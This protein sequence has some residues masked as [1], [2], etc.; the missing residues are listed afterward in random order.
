MVYTS[1]NDFLKTYGIWFAVILCV[2]ILLVVLF[3]FL[4][5]NKKKGG[6]A[7]I[8]Q[9]F[10]DFISSIGGFDNILESSFKGS[11]LSLV[12]KDYSLIDEKKLETLGAS[13]FIKMSN[14]IT[15][16]TNEAEQIFQYIS[17]CKN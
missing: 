16:V 7:Q 13:S 9:L 2:I 10:D 8:K 14:K 5:N 15:I 4:S 6:K 12:L 11:R 17:Q 3:I 1:F